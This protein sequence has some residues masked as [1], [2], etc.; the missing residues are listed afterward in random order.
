M[1]T[2]AGLSLDLPEPHFFSLSSVACQR[3]EEES[4]FPLP[5]LGT[6][7]VVVMD[8]SELWV[9]MCRG[10]VFQSWLVSSVAPERMHDHAVLLRYAE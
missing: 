3:D 4:P 9:V 6:H 2:D 5:H 8:G 1:R 7:G 10:C